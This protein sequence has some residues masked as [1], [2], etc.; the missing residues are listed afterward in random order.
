MAIKALHHASLR[1]RDLP[2]SR[3]FMEAFGLTPVAEQEGKL[4]LRGAGSRAYLLTLEPAA[5]SSLGSLA[6]EVDSIEDLQK[7]ASEHGGSP[8]R[9]ID[10]PGGG[11]TVTL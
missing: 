7:A 6:F 10:A 4:Y 5:T 3:A 11:R 1:V 9:V 2:G 8:I